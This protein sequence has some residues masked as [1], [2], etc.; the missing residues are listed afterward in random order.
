MFFFPLL[1]NLFPELN[2]MDKQINSLK[3][4]DAQKWKAEK[5]AAKQQKSTDDKASSSLKFKG[6][7]NTGLNH[8]LWHVLF[9]SIM[10]EINNF[11]T[12]FCLHTSKNLNCLHE[13]DRQDT[14]FLMFLQN[15]NSEVPGLCLC[16]DK[17]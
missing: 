16:P 15:T 13:Q 12:S 3:P 14:S 5:N 8:C 17:N 7:R 2:S 11:S 1:W 10:L 6:Q 4:E 9:S